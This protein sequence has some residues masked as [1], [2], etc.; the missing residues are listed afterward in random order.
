MARLFRRF[1]ACTRR[2][3]PLSRSL[4]FSLDQ[5]QYDYPDEL[6][7]GYAS[8]QEALEALVRQGATRRYPKACRKN[9]AGASLGNSSFVATKQYRG[10]LSYRVRHRALCPRQRHS[11]PGAR[12]GGEF[13]HLLLPR[14]HRG[15]SR[16]VHDLLFERFVSDA[17]ATSRPTSTSISSTSGAR[18]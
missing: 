7:A 12:L 11:L 18:R 3:D 13:R 9:R 4:D 2:D 8:E 16:Q 1:T 5:L 14:H 17:S 6:R 15:R 10:L